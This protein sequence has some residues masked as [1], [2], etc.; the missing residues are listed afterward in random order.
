MADKREKVF[1]TDLVNS[2]KKQLPTHEVLLRGIARITGKDAPPDEI[3]KDVGEV[4]YKMQNENVVT[5]QIGNTV[6]M[7]VVEE[8]DGK[9]VA[10]GTF[11]NLDIA[12]NMKKNAEKYMRMLR[13]SGVD[14]WILGASNFAKNAY[15]PMVKAVIKKLAAE[16]YRAKIVKS[17]KQRGVFFFVFRISE[18]TVNG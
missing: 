14:H 17:K 4:V 2:K 13:A 15:L 7:H 16:G 1:S 6:F 8:A 11:F 5:E 10:Q 3:Q 18:G 12:P 9:K